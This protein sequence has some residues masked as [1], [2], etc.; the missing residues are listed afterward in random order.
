MTPLYFLFDFV[1]RQYPPSI[2][3][4]EFCYGFVSVTH[5]WQ[6]AF[7]VIATDPYRFR[8]MIVSAIMEKFSYVATLGALYLQGHLRFGQVAFSGPDLIL[9]LL[10]VAAFVKTARSPHNRTLRGKNV[11]ESS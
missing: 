10:F 6:I 11:R 4:P 5:A 3:H 9:G 1:G 7:L 8:P 2:T